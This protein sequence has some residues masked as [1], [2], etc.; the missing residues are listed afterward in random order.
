MP[1]TVRRTGSTEEGAGGHDDPEQDAGHRKVQREDR[2]PR[3][4]R[5]AVPRLV[6]PRAISLIISAFRCDSPPAEG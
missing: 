6:E 5:R 3:N 4:F 1:G 2:K